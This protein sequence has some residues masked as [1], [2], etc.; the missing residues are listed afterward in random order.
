MGKKTILVVVIAGTVAAA[1]ALF[2]HMLDPPIS[3][4]E[5]SAFYTGPAGAASAHEAGITMSSTTSSDVI[6]SIELPPTIHDVD[7]HTM[8]ADGIDLSDWPEMDNDATSGH[9]FSRTTQ[10]MTQ[11]VPRSAE[12]IRWEVATTTDGPLDNGEPDSF[13]S[14]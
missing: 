3:L 10:G 6:G 5:K 8:P 1:P 4:G 11:E 9:I 13:D 7:N 12:R 2:A 14:S